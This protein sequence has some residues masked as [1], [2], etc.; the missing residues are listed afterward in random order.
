MKAKQILIV[1]GIL[2][3]L[4][5]NNEDSVESIN[6]EDSVYGVI[7]RW[8]SEYNVDDPF[9]NMY[10]EYVFTGDG[11]IYADEYRKI[12]GYRRG[13]LRGT[14]KISNNN[15]T[16][17]F[18][19]DEGGQSTIPLKVTDGL[20]F[21]ASFH[22]FSEDYTLSFNRIV[23]EIILTVDS[24]LNVEAS[25]K[26]NI[27]AYTPQQVEIKG[28][29]MSD[30]AIASVD[31][32]G[33]LTT[34]LIGV[35]FM[36]VKTSIGTAVLKISVSDNKNLWNNF[37]LLLGKSFDELETILGRHYALK[38]DSLVRYFYDNSYVDCVDIF[39]H[40]NIVDSICVSFRDNAV[41]DDI[42]KFLGERQA[43][44]KDTLSYSWYTDNT[45]YLL[46]TYSAKYY[47]NENKLI[48]I[49]FDPNWDDR[50]DDYG[51]TLD[52]IVMKYGNYNEREPFE[53]KWV[54]YNDVKNDFVGQIVYYFDPNSHGM[55]RY[56]IVVNMEICPEMISAYLNKHFLFWNSSHRYV[57]NVQING[58]EMLL[59][60]S[61]DESR[62]HT[63]NY[64]F[65]E[66]KNNE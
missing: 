52:E 66:N 36:K 65:E 30:E 1:T 60:V 51:L 31:D 16:T 32:S 21:S 27:E 9:F 15:I 57:K 4:A 37:S 11:A 12:N 58:K 55:Y 40:D 8:Y 6:Y 28:Y 20:T 33:V 59:E 22:R 54:K 34:K 3:L 13:E 42:S 38:N 5:C 44:V 50:R 35:T 53:S 29:D 24:T 43:F 41:E 49:R 62:S 39:R 17:A 45:N 26:Q 23:G 61:I 56:A 2:S 47:K 64:T 10:A 7:G 18:D 48:Y 46:T 63:L 25:V 14:Y 19:I